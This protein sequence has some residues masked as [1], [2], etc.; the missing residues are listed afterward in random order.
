M[1]DINRI[2]LLKV[3]KKARYEFETCSGLYVADNL[4]FK[5][6]FRLDFS[7]VVNELEGVI[8]KLENPN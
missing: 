7:N 6:Y 3:L 4:E 8:K 2:E 5:E 1:N